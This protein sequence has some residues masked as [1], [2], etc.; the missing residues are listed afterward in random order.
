MEGICVKG[1]RDSIETLKC[2][3]ISAIDELIHVS[4]GYIAFDQ[5]LYNDHDH[6]WRIVEIIMGVFRLEWEELS[7]IV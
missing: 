3:H 5:L 7:E 2:R 4:I 1:L 6:I